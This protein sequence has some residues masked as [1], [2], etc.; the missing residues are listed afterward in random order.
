MAFEMLPA[1]DQEIA[2]RCM[3][4]TAAH[5]EDWEK[6]TRLGLEPAELNSVIDQWPNIDDASNTGNGFLAVN[7]CL[8]E[9]CQGFQIESDEWNKWFDTPMADIKRTYETWLSLGELPGGLR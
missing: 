1:K 8:N 9:V 5:I 6:H 7:N 4:A 2:L 3:K